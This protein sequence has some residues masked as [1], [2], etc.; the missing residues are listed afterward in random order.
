MRILSARVARARR[1]PDFGRIEAVVS[2]LVKS[3]GIPVPYEVRVLT[4]VPARTEGGA[5]LRERLVAS[6][7]ILHAMRPEQAMHGHRRARAA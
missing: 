2:L 3:D 6:A 7:K 1:L 4:S 5:G